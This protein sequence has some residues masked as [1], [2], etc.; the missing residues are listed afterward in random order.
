MQC[1]CT[2]FLNIS[3]PSR[4]S[5]MHKEKISHIQK[6]WMPKKALKCNLHLRKITVMVIHSQILTFLL[7][8][9]V[10]FERISQIIHLTFFV[11]LKMSRNSMFSVFSNVFFFSI[12]AT[13]MFSE[14]SKMH[15]HFYL[16]QSDSD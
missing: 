10:Y 16:L 2:Y 8:L 11:F 12:N 3:F 1:N 14:L 6:H 5:V 13:K 4:K 7:T 9:H 15:V